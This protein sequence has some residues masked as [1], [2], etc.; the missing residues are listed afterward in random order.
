ML[1]RRLLGTLPV[2]IAQAVAGF[3]AIWAFTRLLSPE[4]YGRYALVLSAVMLA[5]TLALTWAEAAAYR[6]LP[7][8]RAEGRARD[9]F[10]TL[11]ILAL[12]AGV[13]AALAAAAA[14]MIVPAGNRL[15]P[16]IVFAA[17]SAFCR[18]LTRL[19][20]ESDRADGCVARHSLFES[21]YL[22]AGFAAGAVFAVTTRLG[23]AAPFAGAALA[24]FCVGGGDLARLLRAA[25]GGR[26]EVRRASAYASYG[27]PLALAL[28]V[29]LAVQTATR[30]LIA[31]HA[32]D[33]AVGAFAASFGLASRTLDLV[34][35]WA[36]LACGPLLLDAHS[37]GD[38][39]ALRRAAVGMAQTLLALAVPA[40]V[41]LALVARPLAEAMVGPG[42]RAE[43]TALMPWIAAAACCNGFATHYFSE[44]FQLGERTGQRA[45][46]MLVPATLNIAL[47]VLLL[48]RLGLVGAAVAGVAAAA[49]SV[50]LLSAFGR[51]IVD[52]GWPLD[53]CVKTALAAGAMVPVVLALPATGGWSE[54]FAK[55]G[56]GVMVYA[57]FAIC[58]DIGGLRAVP[59]ALWRHV[60]ATLAPDRSRPA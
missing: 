5:H 39:A 35:V 6:F 19:A 27:A 9:H 16:A 24:G 13:V 38:A 40:A 7:Q 12:A 28:G 52:L 23:P 43:T 34:F 56:A 22:L 51:R 41:G 48:P 3:G 29:D 46:L 57:A 30:A 21:T 2:N 58:L 31:V 37:R 44:A 26:F 4:D 45:A 49:A 42:L 33:A 59:S 53:A 20:R 55:A 17:V 25:R 8:A 60:R 1:A 18:F 36:G 54:V 11:L 47:C 32:G 15:G 10:A 50:A 14:L